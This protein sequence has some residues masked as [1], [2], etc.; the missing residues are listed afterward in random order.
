MLQ[1][2]RTLIRKE[3]QA[4]LRDPNGRRLLMVPVILQIVLFPFAATLEVRNAHMAVFN[5]DG[6]GASVEI[7]QRLA[8]TSAFS[9]VT[10][11]HSDDEVRDV[12]D[13]SKS[14]L[15]LRLDPDFS[16]DMAAGRP[17]A[18]QALMDGRHANSA[19]LAFGYVQA[20]VAA[21]Q[22]ELGS[23]GGGRR[24]LGGVSVA[25]VAIETR[26]WYNPNLESRWFVIP[27][28]VAIITT[29][30]CLIVTALSVA[31]E[32]EQG[33]LDQVLVSPLTPAMIMIGKAIPAML[34]ATAQATIILIAAKL[35]YALPFTGSL[36]LLYFSILIYSLALAGFGLFISAISNTQQQAFLG[37][38]VFMLP[39]ILLSGFV[40]PVENMPD[41]L[42][43]ISWVDPLRHFIPIVT[44]LFLK[45][46]GLAEVANGL[47]PMLL[48]AA[49]TLI[50]AYSIFRKGTA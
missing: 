41:A 35:V 20:I 24:G 12:L 40:S 17:A 10:M 44:G 30:G 45:S 31:R 39:G 8:A 23:S 49:V 26:N 1:R 11:L 32:R 34:V 5:R 46:Y 3:L 22:A 18:A 43:W 29:I 36:L 21:Y 33:T 15:V 9:E 7:V 13:R 4:L 50:S 47:W 38:F 6:G 19:Q 16:R 14:L 48:I 2:L 25:P 42:Q 27:S 28:L 37:V